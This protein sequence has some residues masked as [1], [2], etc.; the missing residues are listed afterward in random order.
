MDTSVCGK[1]FAR[2][3]NLKRHLKSCQGEQQHGG[4][5]E[6]PSRKKVKLSEPSGK[7]E[8][9]TLRPT[10]EKQEPEAS[11]QEAGPSGY[12]RE[13]TDV[14]PSNEEDDEILVQTLEEVENSLKQDEEQEKIKFK[15]T[16]CTDKRRKKFGL[17]RKVFSLRL[18]ENENGEL[19]G[20]YWK[21][22]CKKA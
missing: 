3:D 16:L 20:R 9:A 7:E 19:Q 5:G 14:W 13:E 12:I 6:E 8:E 21:V 22:P 2:N 17:E 4:G 1:K 11:E 18:A 15:L 10:K